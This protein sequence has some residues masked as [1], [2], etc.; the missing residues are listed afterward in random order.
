MAFKT[1]LKRITREQESYLKRLWYNYVEYAERK[2]IKPMDYNKF[3]EK[4]LR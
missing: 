2:N 4:V 3:K 1:K